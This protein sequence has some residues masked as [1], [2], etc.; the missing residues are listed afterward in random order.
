[1]KQNIDLTF[2]SQQELGSFSSFLT[3]RICSS[4]RRNTY[5]TEDLP[6]AV[7]PKY[8]SQKKKKN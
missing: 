5:F 2:C 3:R 8:D 6:L 1:M 4:N 7:S